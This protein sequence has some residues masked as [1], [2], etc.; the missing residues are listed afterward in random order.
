MIS[1]L[2]SARS[3]KWRMRSSVT[4]PGT[5]SSFLLFL[6]F[7]FCCF[8][9]LTLSRFLFANLIELHAL[10][11][12]RAAGVKSIREYEESRL[13]TAQEAAERR[14]TL[15]SQVARLTNQYVTVFYS[16]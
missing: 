13:R 7:D 10:F 8:T 1:Q 5:L 15:S 14:T 2:L 3:A 11:V 12:G 6:S 9:Y 4:S 16:D